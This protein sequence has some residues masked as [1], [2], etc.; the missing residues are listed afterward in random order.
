M[1]Q[2]TTIEQRD[3]ER[4]LTSLRELDD[5]YHTGSLTEYEQAWQTL[6]QQVQLTFPGCTIAYAEIYTAGRERT[7][8]GA[9]R[10]VLLPLPG[11]KAQ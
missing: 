8:H 7:A 5:L 2:C 4:I 3:V 1:N 9:M 6:C 10:H 11:R